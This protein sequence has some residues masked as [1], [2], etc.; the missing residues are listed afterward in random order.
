MIFQ[1]L[2]AALLTLLFSGCFKTN[3]S[4]LESKPHGVAIP[5]TPIL[6]DEM[7]QP[8]SSSNPHP[9]FIAVQMISAGVGVETKDQPANL[10]TT[11]QL[12]PSFAF[13]EAVS[14]AQHIV[15]RSIEQ[16]IAS[17]DSEMCQGSTDF[18]DLLQTQPSLLP[19]C[20]REL[21]YAL[22]GAD[23][24]SV[25]SKAGVVQQFTSWA[26]HRNELPSGE[27]I[28]ILILSF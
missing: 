10:A 2:F 17:R 9:K 12:P 1:F 23:K 7:P 21:A 8:L 19:I 22:V 27:R 11:S 5:L 15:K 24:I 26:T 28:A 14:P 3:D 18:A 16:I 13:I 6:V 25:E 4:I 20:D